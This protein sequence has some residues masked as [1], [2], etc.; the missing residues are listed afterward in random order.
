MNCKGIIYIRI[1]VMKN[2]N[3]CEYIKKLLSKCFY[4]ITHPKRTILYYL[5]SH[6]LKDKNKC[7]ENIVIFEH[8]DIHSENNYIETP[9]Y[10]DFICDE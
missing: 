4:T 1:Y 3:T 2:L 10:S 9:N 5:S 6:N 7:I 8:F